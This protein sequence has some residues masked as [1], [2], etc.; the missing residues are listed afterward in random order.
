MSQEWGRNK[1]AGVW[2]NRN[3][4][5]TWTAVFLAVASM[6]AICAYR[7][8][9]TWTPLQRFYLKTYIRSGLR[10]VASFAK[11][12]RY[13][14]LTVITTKGSHWAAEGEVT[15]VRT[16]S[17]ETTLALT[18]DAVKIGDLRLV[19]QEVQVNSG[20]LHEFLGH[21]I[22]QDQTLMDFLRPALW[23]GSVVFLV[24]LAVAIPKDAARARERREG[25][26]LKGPELVTPGVFNRR[27]RSN[28][29][30]FE[31]TEKTFIQKLFGTLPSVRLPV[32]IEPNH[33]LLMGDT[34]TGK[35]TLIRRIMQQI[36]ERGETAIV[37]DPALDY[38]PEFYRPERG[39]AVLNPLDQRMPYWSPGD[40]LRHPAEALTLATSLFPDRRNENQ[41]FVEGP[42]KI[43]AHL[44]TFRPTPEQMAWWMCHEEEIDQRVKGTQYAAMIDKQAPA[45]RSGVL[46]SLN[47]V[48][49]CLK[50]LPS[51]NEANGR[52]SAA[53]WS[54]QRKGWVFLTSTSE[55]RERLLPLTSLWLDTLVLRLMN[56]GQT[57]ARK[58]WFV[59]DELATLQRL[60][61]LHTAVTENRKSN[62]PVV[63]GF[64][65][66]SQ[67]ETRYGHEAEA[68]LSQPATK[69]FLR[70]S[71]PHAAKWISDTIGRIEIERLRESRSSGQMGGK[72][73]T[74]SY[75]NERD[76]VPLVMDSEI[77]GLEN[78]HGYLKSGNLVV[79]MSFP[80]VELP[81]MH[82]RF[83]QRPTEI[84]PEEPPKTATAAAGASGGR[85]QKL[86]QQEIKQ[87]REQELKQSRA[88]QGHFFR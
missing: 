25:R 24:C 66:R 37:Y 20:K 22:Y 11:S 80:F 57:S 64:Q 53:E 82:Q 9:K 45:Q 21:W 60:P 74:T 8:T 36:E 79:R 15:D 78:L 4:A 49:D 26:R 3:A 83:I 10:S 81:I 61:Q 28:G 86:T 7:Y 56:Q 48:A 12:D 65:G 73:N 19:S 31:L 2:P 72:R 55:T 71:E 16:A 17:G 85:E 43:F 32:A 42:R 44:L 14:M 62:N 27:N 58:V 52:W 18:D 30:G 35:S 13:S 70:T 68:M 38:T 29:I 87:D 41:F 59:L 51:E 63:L 77:T 33:I 47:M 6:V 76:V 69:I 23:G 39:D 75:N 40:E 34:G 67:L 1:Y 5:W 84:R 50:L 46:A 54:K 88:W